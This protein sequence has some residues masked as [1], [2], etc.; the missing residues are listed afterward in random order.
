MKKNQDKNKLVMIGVVVLLVV[1]T[2]GAWAITSNKHGQV[3]IPIVAIIIG[4]FAIVITAMY[5][6]NR[7]SDAE[8]G[9]PIVDERGKK[10]MLVAAAK[11]YILSIWFLLILS[12]LSDEVIHFRDPS[13]AL[14]AG[15]IGMALL[16]GIT[17]LWYRRIPNIDEVKF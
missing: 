10:V 14:G 3:G 7:F 13:Q 11:A 16:L 9:M 4:I 5:I 1:L 2:L 6:R 8:K 15:I 12:F 17:W